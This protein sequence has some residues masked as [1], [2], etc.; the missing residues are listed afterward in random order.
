MQSA[1]QMNIKVERFELRQAG[2]IDH[3]S[4]GMAGSE[5][6]LIQFDNL[7]DSHLRQ[8]VE[9]AARYRLPAIY[10]NRWHV[11]NGGLISYGADVRDNWRHGASYVDRILR[12]ARPKDLPVYQASRFELVINLNAA[13]PLGLTIPSSLLASAD[14]VIE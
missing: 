9:L 11:V 6:V 13:K 3:A 10:D 5:A 2:D 7:I 8:I 4:A 1:E 12:G 14:E